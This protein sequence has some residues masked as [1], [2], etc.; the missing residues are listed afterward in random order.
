LFVTQNRD[1]LLEKM[2]NTPTK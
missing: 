2:H 1:F